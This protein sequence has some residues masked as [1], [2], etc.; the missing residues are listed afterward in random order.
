[1][2]EWKIMFPGG[3]ANQSFFSS[4]LIKAGF[5]LK[6]FSCINPSKKAGSYMPAPCLCF[7]RLY[8]FL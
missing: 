6:A 5:L 7:L 3:G 1:V 4:A 2:K 8:Y